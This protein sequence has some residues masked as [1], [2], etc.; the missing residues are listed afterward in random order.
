MKV[1]TSGPKAKALTEI[2]RTDA[3]KDKTGV[4]LKGITAVN[5]ANGEKVPVYV[6]DYVLAGYGTGAVMAVPAHDERDFAFAKKYNLQ[7]KQVITPVFYD[8]LNPVR[9]GVQN[10]DRHGLIIVIKHW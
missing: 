2:E 3:K 1:P 8:K 9:E 6:A 10:V 7:I 5:P 4:E